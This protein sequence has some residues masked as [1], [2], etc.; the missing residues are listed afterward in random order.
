[1]LGDLSVTSSREEVREHQDSVV[2]SLRIRCDLP[3]LLTKAYENTLGM[4]TI[5]LIHSRHTVMANE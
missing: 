1:M 2:T 5:P 4:R 3:N